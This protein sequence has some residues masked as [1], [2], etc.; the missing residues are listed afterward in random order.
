MHVTF[1]TDSS[2]KDPMH[3]KN[4][5]TSR[6]CQETEIAPEIFGRILQSILKKIP[7]MFLSFSFFFMGLIHKPPK[8]TSENPHTFLIV[9]QK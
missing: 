6:K 8:D 9:F 4:K 1:G 2:Q 5:G 7:G 3:K